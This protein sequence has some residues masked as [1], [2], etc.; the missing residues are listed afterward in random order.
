MPSLHCDDL[1]TSAWQ[2]RL[3]EWAAEGLSMVRMAA[4]EGYKYFFL[5]S[6]R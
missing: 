4:M 3:M 2:N 5:I 6:Q 1:C